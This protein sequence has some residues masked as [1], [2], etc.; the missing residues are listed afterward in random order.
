MDT[1]APLP[2][3]QPPVQPAKSSGGKWVLFGCGGCLVLIVIG[4]LAAGG[5]F[6]FVFGAIKNTEA[7]TTALKRAQ[8]SPEVQAALGTP[9]TPSYFVTGAVST[10]NVQSTAD[11]SIPITGPNGAGV[12]IAKATKTGDAAWVFSVLQFLNAK[13]GQ[14]T[15][16]LGAAPPPP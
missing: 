7:Y 15:D 16:L 5:I 13:T 6:M 8:D 12:V 2:P 10:D 11:L 14:T 9:I 4:A 1:P 3:A